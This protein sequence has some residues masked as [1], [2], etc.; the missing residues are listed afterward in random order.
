MVSS[1][2]SKRRSAKKRYVLQKPKGVITPRVEKVG[3]QRFGIVCIDCGKQASRWMMADFFGNVLIPP[4]D[5]P[6]TRGHLRAAIE[7]IRQTCQQHDLG[8]LLIAIEQTGNYHKPVQ[9]AFRQ[10]GW[11]T[12]LVHPFATKQFRQPAD[13]GNKTDDR[14]LAA[15]HRAAVLGFALLE[16]PWPDDYRCLQLLARQR[17]DLVRKKSKL[18]CQIRESLHDRLPGYTNLFGHHFWDRAVAVPLAR[19][20]RTADSFRQAGVAGLQ[21]FLDSASLRCQ[22]T[23]LEKIIAW[24]DQVPSGHPHP[25]L[26]Q[27]QFLHLDDDRLGKNRLISDFERDLAGWLTRTPYV[28][29]LIIPGINVPSCAELAGELGPIENYANANAITGRAALM[30]SRYQSADVDQADGG[31][32]RCGNRRLRAALLQI[33][34]NLMLHNHYFRGRSELWRRQGKDPRWMHIKVAKTFSRLAFAIVAGRQLV[35]HRCCQRQ[36]YLLAKLLTFHQEHGTP[37][38]VRQRDLEQTVQQM[39]P[40]TYAREAQPLQ[41]QLDKLA[42]RHKGPTPLSEILPVVLAKLGVVTVQSPDSGEGASG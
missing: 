8:D 10:T 36:H 35:G 22:P 31:L 32:R 19:Q 12:R 7:Q 4:A 37:W 14:D 18:H 1:S 15:L 23:T 20:F 42:H 5:L 30:P 33:A 21:R 34:D 27:R 38:P 28:L 29:L 41:E 16:P 6:H 11:D 13:A 3:P 25:D 26:L 40:S 39:P 2:R 9:Q 17:R 24:T